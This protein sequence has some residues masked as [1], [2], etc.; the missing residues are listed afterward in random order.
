MKQYV[1]VFCAA[2]AL[3]LAACGGAGTSGVLG[4]GPPPTATPTT[5]PSS[6]AARGTLVDDVTG[7]PLGGIKVRLD[8]WAQYPTPG[9][10]PTPI[11]EATTDPSG[12]FAITAPN[13]TY[14]LV[15]G[16]D[17]VDTPPPGWSTPA[18]SATDTPIPG[19][20]GWYATVHDR[21]VL[22]GQTTLVA[23]TMPPEPDF[24]PPGTELGGAYRLATIDPLTEAPCVLAYNQDRIAHGLPSAVVD[25]WLLENSRAIVSGERIASQTNSGGTAQFLTGGT[26]HSSNSGGSNCAAATLGGTNGDF[27][28][29]S[30]ALNAQALWFSGYYKAYDGI[31]SGFGASQF[32]VDPRWPDATDPGSLP[33]WP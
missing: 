24:T 23:P 32:L 18:P 28:G 29:Q 16:P 11:A 8:P 17:S 9:P 20:S 2:S 25:E 6:T 27:Q 5:T 15:I 31:I 13:G 10:T 30:Q 1:P 22:N 14:L 21:L 33:P 19:A 4:G 12:H 26:G 3:A 7:A